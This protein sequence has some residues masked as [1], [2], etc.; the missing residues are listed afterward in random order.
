MYHLL[1]KAHNAVRITTTRGGKKTKSQEVKKNTDERAKLMQEQVALRL[2]WQVTARH[3]S[4]SFCWGRLPWWPCMGEQGSFLGAEPQKA[5][6]VKQRAMLIYSSLDTRTTL[7]LS[8]KL[9]L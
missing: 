7:S 6:A 5:A 3:G 4:S 9:P 2:L 8:P 1:K